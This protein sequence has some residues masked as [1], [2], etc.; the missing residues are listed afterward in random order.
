MHEQTLQSVTSAK[1]LGITLQHDTKSDQH[2]SNIIVKA[3]K[4]LAF[5]RQNLKIGAIRTKQLTYKSLVR[6]L[7]EYASTVWDPHINKD[8]SRIKMVQRRAACF[9]LQDYRHTASVDDMT[10]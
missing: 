10:G 5:L 9:V 6:P 3:S 7:L 4:T 1:Y 8:T 2:I